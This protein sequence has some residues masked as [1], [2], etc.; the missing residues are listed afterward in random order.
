[1]RPVR[2]PESPRYHS[3][4]DEPPPGFCVRA[5]FIVRMVRVV[6]GRYYSGENIYDVGDCVWGGD[7]E[8]RG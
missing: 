6:K 7:D 1:M 5:H 4:D 2:K 8:R 3:E